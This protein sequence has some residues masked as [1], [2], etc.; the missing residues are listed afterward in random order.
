M[1]TCN[2][3]PPLPISVIVCEAEDI[4]QYI[5]YENHLPSWFKRVKFCTKKAQCPPLTS[6]ASFRWTLTKCFSPLNL[7]YTGLLDG[8]FC[9]P[10]SLSYTTQQPIMSS[11]SQY[12]YVEAHHSQHPDHDQLSLDKQDD[13]ESWAG[14][15]VY[16]NNGPDDPHDQNNRPD[17]AFSALSMSPFQDLPEEGEDPSDD[18]HPCHEAEDSGSDQFSHGP[19]APSG[20]HTMCLTCQHLYLGI[21]TYQPRADGA[22]PLHGSYTATTEYHM[23]GYHAPPA[24]PPGFATSNHGPTTYSNGYHTGL[25]YDQVQNWEMHPQSGTSNSNYMPDSQNTDSFQT[26]QQ[27]HYPPSENEIA[28][29]GLLCPCN[30]DSRYDRDHRDFWMSEES[31]GTLS[32]RKHNR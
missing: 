29:F 14:D 27:L 18:Y 20:G 32:T 10:L 6:S 7:I 30:G 22:C 21:P 4:P 31:W 24:H 17:Q 19:P 26:Q 12:Y 23:A 11:N 3:Q 16:A 2:S 15:S 28:E 25:T 9:L 5:I 8:G 1:D 13:D